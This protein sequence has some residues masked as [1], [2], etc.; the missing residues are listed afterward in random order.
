MNIGAGKITKKEMGGIP[1]YLLDV[2][3]PKRKFT[4]T[5]YRA[6]AISAIRSILRRGKIPFL[7]GGTGFYIKAVTHDM[8]IPDVPP[9]WKLR[10]EFEKKSVHELFAM[11]KGLDPARARS[12]E[13]KNKRRLIRALE[14]VVKTGKPVPKF[15]LKPKN[16]Y[17]L[18]MI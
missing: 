7:V 13:Q 3:S 9:D 1:H 5:Q 11:L 10:G 2:A 12:I 18:L 17:R 15:P 16:R 4:I 6:K 14:I 8:P